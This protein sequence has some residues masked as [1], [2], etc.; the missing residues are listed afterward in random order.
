MMLNNDF[1]V[2]FQNHE[3]CTF[4]ALLLGFSEQLGLKNKDLFASLTF[5]ECYNSEY[6]N[7]FIA[8]YPHVHNSS[9]QLI[10]SSLI[11]M[12]ISIQ[13]VIFTCTVNHRVI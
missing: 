5:P 8:A 13:S 12:L 4:I 1:T 10:N 9:S 6:D 2:T 7:L 11:G 3:G